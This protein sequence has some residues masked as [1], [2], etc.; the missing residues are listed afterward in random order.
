MPTDQDIH[1]CLDRAYGKTPEGQYAAIV[2]ASLFSRMTT[3]LA[4]DIGQT[5]LHD[6][7][8][9]DGDLRDVVA[10][11]MAA[12]HPDGRYELRS[13][14]ADEFRVTLGPVGPGIV[15]HGAGWDAYVGSGSDVS[16]LRGSNGFNPIGSALS[17]IL[18][19]AHLA[20]R[21]PTVR[22]SP[23]L[24]NALT[25]R[26]EPAT[27]AAAMTSLQ[28]ISS[29]NLWIVG[30]G[31]VGTATLFFLTGVTRSFQPVLVD[32]DAVS[33]ENITRSPLF[34]WQDALAEQPKV[35]V[36]ERFLKDSGVATVKSFAESL[37]GIRSVWT[38]RE[39]GTPDALVATANERAVRSLIESSLPPLQVYATTGKSWQ[40][41]LIRHIPLIDA[42]SRCLPGLEVASAPPLC[43]TDATVNS[44]LP[45][46]GIDAAL[47]FLSY[48]AGLMTATELVKAELD[49]Y[50]FTPNRVFFEAKASK[51]FR[52]VRL[53]TRGD[54]ACRT[55]DRGLQSA[56]IVG[57]RHAHLSPV[58]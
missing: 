33:V 6:S 51:P 44:G 52:H 4:F 3:R 36:V 10:Q 48:M 54:C 14:E 12:A 26:E 23:L 47:P 13:A 29:G 18:A 1:I 8:P 24:A 43:A 22:T 17:V 27:G 19:A 20:S 32:H 25:W 39:Q 37:D 30:T 7:L 40:C 56:A 45:T 42:C 2:A 38:N 21:G 46:N 55:R 31:S 58:P 5:A 16:P 9:W 28:G 34:T 11:S 49:G 57:S 35:V 50:P 15:A 53:E 41:T